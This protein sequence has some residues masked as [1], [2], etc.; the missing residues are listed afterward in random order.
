LA[1]NLFKDLALS[2]VDRDLG[3]DDPR[4]AHRTE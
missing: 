4:M 1:T 3:S 2:K